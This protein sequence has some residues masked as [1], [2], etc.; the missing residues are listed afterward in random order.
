MLRGPRNVLLA[1]V[2]AIAAALLS[3]GWQA[4]TRTA[5]LLFAALVV[6]YELTVNAIPWKEPD[7]TLP[8]RYGFGA[9]LLTLCFAYLAWF[10]GAFWPTWGKGISLGVGAFAAGVTIAHARLRRFKASLSR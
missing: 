4:S 9:L 5:V 6:M 8:I 1:V 2:F 10:L 3:K 7:Q